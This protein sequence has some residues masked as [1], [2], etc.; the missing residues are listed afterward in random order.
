MLKTDHGFLMEQQYI[1]T[2][3]PEHQRIGVEPKVEYVLPN[4][5]LRPAYF[6]KSL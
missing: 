5:N 1:T 3:K 2:S 6:G 4:A